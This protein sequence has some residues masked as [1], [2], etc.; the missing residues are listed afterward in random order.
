[1]SSRRLLVLTA[2]PLLIVGALY[3]TTMPRAAVGRSTTASNSATVSPSPSHDGPAAGSD[4]GEP[5]SINKQCQ[6]TADELAHALKGECHI[7]VRAPY[8]LVGDMSKAELDRSHRETIVP[9]ARALSIMYF[10]RPPVHPVTIFL[11]ASEKSYQRYAEQLDGRRQP[12]YAGYYLRSGRRIVLNASTGSGTLAHELTHALAHFD[13]PNMP[14]W[15]DEGLASLQ[16][17]SDFS[18]D[19]LRLSGTSNWR[20]NYL[21][22]AI[23]QSR[24]RSIASLVAS[25]EIQSG[26]EAIDYAHARYFCLYLQKRRLLGPFYRKF[27]ANVA[28]DPT[29]VETLRSL[30]GTSSLDDVDRSFRAWVLSLH[31]VRRG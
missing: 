19:G 23:R 3:W 16:E 11:L 8:V 14:E 15:F 24:L 31:K 28:G 12:N 7:V 9:T 6:V 18:D 4:E 13:F 30:L 5:E 10:D 29:G 20:L 25:T 17:Q 2:G 21:I 1:M 22:P 27:R 26:H